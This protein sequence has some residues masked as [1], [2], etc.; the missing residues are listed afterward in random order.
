[1][2]MTVISPEIYQS[3]KIGFQRQTVGCHSHAMGSF[4]RVFVPVWVQSSK[5]VKK[6]F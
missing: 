2:Y 3:T 1:M 6:E 4:K 5:I